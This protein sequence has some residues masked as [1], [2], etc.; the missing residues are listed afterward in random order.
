MINNSAGNNSMLEIV[1]NVAADGRADI[2]LDVGTA[3]G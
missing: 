1:Q 2:R 3:V